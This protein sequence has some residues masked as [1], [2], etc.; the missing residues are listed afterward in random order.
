MSAIWIE[1]V[2]RLVAFNEGLIPSSNYSLTANLN[3]LTRVTLVACVIIALFEPALAVGTF[4]TI[5]V[6]LLAIYYVFVNKENYSEIGDSSLES[7]S[8][9]DSRPSK[10]PPTKFRFCNDVD[11][12]QYDEE[13]SSRNQML[14]GGPNPKTLIPPIIAPPSHQLAEWK[15]TDLTVH[16]AINDSTGFDVDRSGFV[17]VPS[18]PKRVEFRPPICSECVVAPC[19]CSNPT[20]LTQTVQPGVYY[21]TDPRPD[22]INALIGISE[23]RQFEPQRVVRGRDGSVT[24]YSTLTDSVPELKLPE[25]TV[26]AQTESNVYDPRFTGYGPSNRGYIDPTT[27]SP[28]WFYD[29][30][31]AVTMP[32]FIARN[33]IDVYPWA[34]QYGSGVNGSTEAVPAALCD[35]TKLVDRAFEDATI[36]FRTELQ[37]RL[38]RK[39]NNEMWQ[40]RVAPI[41]TLG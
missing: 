26:V 10:F 15:A 18:D 41:R 14:V 32:N 7:C 31:S 9:D 37:E 22:P 39:R 25:L 19:R 20:V 8:R 21:E 29:D 4:L 34:A 3:A 38:M 17:N 27:G 24:Y 16:S 23:Q 33:D 2:T 40:Q 11:P 30:V 1:D 5:S 6:I 12:I 36:K 13:F 28:R 35:T